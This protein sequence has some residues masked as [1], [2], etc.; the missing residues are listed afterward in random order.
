MLKKGFWR[1]IY[2]KG[3][4]PPLLPVHSCLI[5]PWFVSDQTKRKKHFSLLHAIYWTRRPIPISRK[6]L[7]QAEKLP[8]N[9]Q[10]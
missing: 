1:K 7:G 4:R 6:A 3:R 10:T 2:I 5:C 9:C 8:N